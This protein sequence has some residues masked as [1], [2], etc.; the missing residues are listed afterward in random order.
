MLKLHPV[1]S[2]ERPRIDKQKVSCARDLPRRCANSSSRIELPE[3]SRS[4]PHTQNGLKPSPFHVQN[5]PKLSSRNVRPKPGQSNRSERR[6]GSYTITA[7]RTHAPT[8]DNRPICR[9]QKLSL[10][11]PGR[12]APPRAPARNAPARPLNFATFFLRERCA[13]DDQIAQRTADRWRTI[14]PI[15]LST[16]ASVSFRRCRESAR[17]E[18]DPL[19]R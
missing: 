18:P 12:A 4:N 5:G 9:S 14:S 11:L 19:F 16:P 8:R 1:S 2:I 10:P 3:F 7:A 17:S 13:R 15:R 6:P